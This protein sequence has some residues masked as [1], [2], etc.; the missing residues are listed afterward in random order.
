MMLLH[1][2]SLLTRPFT[3][4]TVTC[5]RSIHIDPDGDETVVPLSKFDLSKPLIGRTNGM[6]QR[7]EE[8]LVLSLPLLFSL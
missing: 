3:L 5:V 2:I 1:R 4:R 7:E 6:N 8:I